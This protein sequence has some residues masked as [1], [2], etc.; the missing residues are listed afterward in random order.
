MHVITIR[1]QERRGIYDARH[2]GRLLCTSSRSPLLAAARVLLAEGVDPQARIVMRR[3]G[4]D[5]D[6]LS[7]TIGAAAK[8]SVEDNDV[9]KPTFRRFR[10]HRESRGAAPLV[11][12][13]AEEVVTH[14]AVTQI[15]RDRAPHIR[16]WRAP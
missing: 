13:P 10:D 4:S 3:E 5:V 12:F 14:T 1:E 8:L 7:S 16:A 11:S 15:V 6:C 9:G 2:D